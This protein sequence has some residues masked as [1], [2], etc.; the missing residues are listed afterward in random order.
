[1]SIGWVPS[2]LCG[3]VA[4]KMKIAFVSLEFEV[5]RYVFKIKMCLLFYSH[6]SRVR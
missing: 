2:L 5:R 1:M 4:C 6:F 3:A